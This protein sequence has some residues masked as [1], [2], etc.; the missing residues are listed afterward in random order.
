MA[1]VLALDIDGTLIGTGPGA[2][3]RR[4][5]KYLFAL[6]LELLRI[7]AGDSPRGPRGPIGPK[8]KSDG[9]REREPMLLVPNLDTDVANLRSQQRLFVAWGEQVLGPMVRPGLFEFLKAVVAMKAA[10]KFA[11]VV[12]F[13]ANEEAWV[14]FVRLV[15]ETLAGVEGLFDAVVGFAS[16]KSKACWA[17]KCTK[18][19]DCVRDVLASCAGG[20]GTGSGAG[21]G[22]GSGAGAAD[23]DKISVVVVDDKPGS[24]LVG[25]PHL[26]TVIGVHAHLM[27][28]D[29]DTI[30]P[31]GAATALQNLFP[32][33]IIDWE[34]MEHF[35]DLADVR[36]P[37]LPSPDASDCP[38]LESVLRR[39]DSG[40]GVL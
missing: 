29:E 30:H 33:F 21:A 20:A 9:Y 1:V 10:G 31:A 26:D 12:L 8:G 4:V 14:E 13:S 38:D 3:R 36:D 32:A 18:S 39:L 15:L 19:V 23:P 22:T 28:S 2:K 6:M 5:I 37:V 7:D 27:A 16:L 34:Q 17:H 24:V 25:V 11:K 40:S 35:I